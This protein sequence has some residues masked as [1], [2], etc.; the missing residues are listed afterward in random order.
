MCCRLAEAHG[1]E[2]VQVYNEGDGVSAFTGVQR[3]GW[4]R[5]LTDV[6]DG[7]LDVLVAQ[8]ED[9]FARKLTDKAVLQTVCAAAGA[10]WLTVNE[11]AT[12]PATADG[13]FLS[14]LRGGLSTMESRRKSERQRQRNMER[15]LRGEAP[16][17]GNR[18]FGYGVLIGTKEIRRQDKSTREWVLVEVEDFD[19]DQLHP[20]EAP[21]IANAYR[22]FVADEIT[23]SGIR[24]EWNRHGVLTVRGKPWDLP[25]VEK[26]LRRGRNAGFVEHRPTDP[27]TGRSV[28]TWGAPVLD[29]DGNRVR[30]RWQTVVDEATYDAA[31]AKLT[32]PARRLSKVRPPKHLCSSIAKCHCGT[33]LRVAGRNQ[34]ELAY[35][36]GVHDGASHKTP[37]FRHVSIRCDE[38][39]AVVREAVV[40]ALMFS[41]AAAIPDADAD[42]L[43][44]LLVEL[45]K[46]KRA[47]ADLLTLMRAEK[48]AGEDVAD[49]MARRA[50]YARQVEAIE[51]RRAEIIQSNAQ[52]DLLAHVRAQ[53]I[54]GDAVDAF[55]ALSEGRRLSFDKAAEVRDQ[56]SAKFDAMPL[57]QRRTLVRAYVR[58]MVTPGRGPKRVLIEHRVATNL[59]AVD[60]GAFHE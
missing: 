60:E 26:V 37:G 29:S 21:L 17:G 11:G 36:C 5:M 24:T 56:L 13:E 55:G 41:T 53:L 50:E 22:R 25:K 1:I 42:E 38:L 51:G 34:G 23:L 48:A 40:S 59:D 18:P 16:R 28:S 44:R 12:D 7:K 30:G 33:S 6:G 4:E 52:A 46:T 35:R 49:V 45:S 19:V 58:V 57:G 39:D 10:T 9:R 14:T 3:P 20:E 8:S 47:R 31:M 54:A 43:A 27:A 32:D 15:R 2:V